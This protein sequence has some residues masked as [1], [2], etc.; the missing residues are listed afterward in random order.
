MKTTGSVL[1]VVQVHVTV[2]TTPTNNVSIGYYDFTGFQESIQHLDL[3][4]I[5]L[6]EDEEE[7]TPNL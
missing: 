3:D 4:D 7:E 2:D 5:P 6:E 1:Q